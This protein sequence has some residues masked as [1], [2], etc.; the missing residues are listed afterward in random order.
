LQKPPISKLTGGGAANFS[1]SA[2]NKG[3]PPST[4]KGRTPASTSW[5][6]CWASRGC[7][8]LENW[9]GR[10]R[11]PYG[12]RLPR[13]TTCKRIL[14][15]FDLQARNAEGCSMPR[16]CPI[17]GA[18]FMPTRIH[19]RRSVRNARNSNNSCFVRRG[20]CIAHFSA[21]AGKGE[22]MLAKMGR[23]GCSLYR[24]WTDGRNA[25]RD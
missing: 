9:A 20:A 4:E 19:G 3:F 25:S 18:T 13:Q 24:W 10:R 7:S 15:L 21:T 16:S 17:R 22:G 6:G 23:R 12:T 5:K 8:S 14:L 2:S 11:T 1:R